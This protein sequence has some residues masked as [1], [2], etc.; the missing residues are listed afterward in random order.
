MRITRA[1]VIVGCLL[2]AAILFG[3]A[4]RVE[5]AE[6]RWSAADLDPLPEPQANGWALLAEIEQVP[7]LPA[8]LAEWVGMASS[9]DAVSTWKMRPTDEA[10]I[11]AFLRQPEVAEILRAWHAAAKRPHFVD[12]CALDFDS[13]CPDFRLYQIHQVVAIEVLD[14]LVRGNWEAAADVTVEMLEVSARYSSSARTMLGAATSIA[15]HGLALGLFDVV[16]YASPPFKNV[17]WYAREKLDTLE[18][19]ASVDPDL[20]LAVVGEYIRIADMLRRMTA[21]EVDPADHDTRLP[22]WLFDRDRTVHRINAVFDDYLACAEGRSLSTSSS[23][24]APTGTL[25]DRLLN[26]VGEQLLALLVPSVF[27]EQCKRH[28]EQ[29]TKTRER[30]SEIIERLSSP[31]QHPSERVR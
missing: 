3:W 26:P 25:T 24:D 31:R 2:G 11:S 13:F 9:I 12:G 22:R 14:H 10:A 27:L 16:D 28:H 8:D 17:P 4:T 30:R 19:H 23:S 5:R 21:G 15:S 1:L 20:R 7:Q 6:L 18:H 29:V